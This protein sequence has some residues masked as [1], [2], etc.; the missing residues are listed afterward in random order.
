MNKQKYRKRSINTENKLVV[1]L[2][3][4]KMKIQASRYRM[5]KSWGYSDSKRI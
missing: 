2:W 3:M 5:I 4:G 1:A